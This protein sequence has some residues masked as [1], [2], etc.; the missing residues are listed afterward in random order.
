MYF[1]RK[2][3]VFCNWVSKSS[4]CWSKRNT[5]NI[6]ELE[7]FMLS[8]D[9]SWLE[10][11]ITF[12]DLWILNSWYRVETLSHAFTSVKQKHISCYRK[13]SKYAIN[14]LTRLHLKKPDFFH[15]ISPS[16]FYLR[17][18]KSTLKNMTFRHC[19]WKLLTEKLF[20]LSLSSC[21]AWHLWDAH[22]VNCRPVDKRS[23]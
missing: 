19:S 15:F 10:T 9:F 5:E 2:R 17:A 21:N 20:F 13:N 16:K 14:R 1:V 8:D 22:K 7:L 3:Q 18:K 23:R 4:T 11:L 12:E 6:V